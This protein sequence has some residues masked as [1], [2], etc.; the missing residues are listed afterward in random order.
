MKEP[1]AAKVG[2]LMALSIP[3]LAGGLLTPIIDGRP[4][5]NP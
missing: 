1:T 3:A 5:G 2:F 4:I